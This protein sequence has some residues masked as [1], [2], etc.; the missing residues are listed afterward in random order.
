MGAL[1]GNNIHECMMLKKNNTDRRKQ[2]TQR[3]LREAL[4]ALMFE[5]RYDDILVQD[6]LD[7]A[8]IGRSTFYTYFPD[9]N[10][11]LLDSLQG[12]HTFLRDVQLATPVVSEKA[13]EKVIG[14]SLAMFEHVHAHQQLHQS[15]K[16]GGW[17]LVSQRIED[18]LVQL[19]KQEARP[20]FKQP[21]SNMPFDLLMHVLGAT[22]MSVLTW[23]QQSNWVLSPQEINALFRAL[24][25]P[26]LVECLS[27]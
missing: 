5:K 22:Y 19:M 15:L 20:L 13:Y 16:G 7:R 11:L 3:A 24:V 23:W 17:I 10:A 12:L 9:K 8:D 2:K 25:I 1:S 4:H 18:I 14:F 26:V 27:A 21:A 6:I